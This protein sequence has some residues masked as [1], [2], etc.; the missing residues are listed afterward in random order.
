MQRMMHCYS[1]KKEALNI[2]ENRAPK[3]RLHPNCLADLGA[4][5]WTF[6]KLENFPDSN[7]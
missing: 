6:E 2:P 5:V 7:I 4:E 3:A 1:W